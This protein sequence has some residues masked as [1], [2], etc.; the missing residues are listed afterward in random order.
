[1]KNRIPNFRAVVMW[2]GFCTCAVAIVVFG[3]LVGHR[4]VRAE[5]EERARLKSAPCI[6]FQDLS[7]KDVPA[8]CLT[9]FTTPPEKRQ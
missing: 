1:M 2:L 4:A 3:V 5:A 8:R 9:Y 7:Q 6:E